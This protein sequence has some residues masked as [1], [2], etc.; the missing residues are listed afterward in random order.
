MRDLRNEIIQKIEEQLVPHLNDY[1]HTLVMATVMSVLCDYEVTE[2]STAIIP[3]DDGNERLVKTYSSNMLLNG[4]AKSTIQAYI[5]EIKLFTEFIGNK[6]LKSATTFDLRN[7]LAACKVRGLAN[8]SIENVRAN[9]SAFYTWLTAEEYIGKNP[10]LAVKPIKCTTKEKKPFSRVEIDCLRANCKN[11]QERAIIEVLLSSGLRVS[12]LTNLNIEDI[13]FDRLEVH[14]KNGK[15]GKDRITY[16]DELAYSHLKQYLI[17]SGKVSGSV[18]SSQRSERYTT[19]G[20]RTL[21]KVLEQRS[22]V[23][24]VHPHRFRRTLATTLSARGM[25]IQDI[26]SILGHSNINTT[27]IYIAMDKEKVQSAYKQFIA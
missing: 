24:N 23:P 19:H 12:E 18:F 16:I 25:K 11:L 14:V 1:T 3:F 21:L 6:D 5:R 20:I 13:D 22:G 10:C 4:L 9:L 8:T 2:R 17:A 26:Q 7:Y 27:M 15:G